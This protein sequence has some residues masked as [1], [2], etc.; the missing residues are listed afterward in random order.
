MKTLPCGNRAFENSQI[1]F[2]RV[3]KQHENCDFDFK[4][5]TKR[6]SKRQ[7]AEIMTVKTLQAYMVM[8]RKY[9]RVPTWQ[10]LKAFANGVV[11]NYG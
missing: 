2:L 1:H 10:G 6:M 9:E 4:R 8:C 3:Q 11:F 5:F 7:E